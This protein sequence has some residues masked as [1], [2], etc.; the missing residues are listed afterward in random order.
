[1]LSVM[2]RCDAYA[3]TRAEVVAKDLSRLAMRLGVDCVVSVNGIDMLAVA[4]GPQANAD[5]TLKFW[6]EG[7]MEQE[8]HRRASHARSA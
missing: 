7:C 2:I 3:G 4:S 5:A 6:E 1:M 8:K